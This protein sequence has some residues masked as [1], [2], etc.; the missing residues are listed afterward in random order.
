MSSL[1]SPTR[2]KFGKLNNNGQNNNNNYRFYSPV[3]DLITEGEQSDILR[4]AAEE[5]EALIMAVR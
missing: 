5:R 2:E 4:L 1:L 3:H